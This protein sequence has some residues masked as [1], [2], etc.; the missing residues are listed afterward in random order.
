MS[1]YDK[2]INLG[3][4]VDVYDVLEAFGVTCPARAHAIKKLLYMNGGICNDTIHY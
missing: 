2:E 3:V 4:V 1:K